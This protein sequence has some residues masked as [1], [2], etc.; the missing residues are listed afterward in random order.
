MSEVQ[1]NCGH[2]ARKTNWAFRPS[3]SDYICF[4]YLCQLGMRNSKMTI[5]ILRLIKSSLFMAVILLTNMF[6]LA[7]AD[8]SDLVV[9]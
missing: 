2:S 3:K 6:Q 1:D 5:N 8:L 7:F 9:K 4:K